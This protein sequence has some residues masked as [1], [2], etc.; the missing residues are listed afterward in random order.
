MAKAWDAEYEAGR[1]RDEAPVGFVDDIVAAARDVGLL[2]AKGLY[3]GCGNGRNY[4]PLGAAGLDLLG[5]DVSATAL[6][7]LAER[8]P[9]RREQLIHGDLSALPDGHRFALVIAIQVFQHGDRARAHSHIR[10]A[11]ERLAPGGLFC[12]RVNAVGTDV[13]PRH[14]ITERHRD[15][16]FTV[17]YLEG[18]KQGLPIH[19]FS[20]GELNGLCAGG[21]EPVLPLRLHET[22]RTLPDTG[23]WSQWEAI[24]RSKAEPN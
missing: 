10:S 2:E 20:A 4:L 18:P 11:Q 17:L 1:Y 3:I 13:A 21:Y 5:L 8:A 7:Q 22:Y 12:V 6:E 23:Q 19:F 9:E 24:W 16:G 14:E 15:G